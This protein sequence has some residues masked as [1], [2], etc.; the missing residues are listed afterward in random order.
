MEDMALNQSTV[1]R[2]DLLRQSFMPVMPAPEDHNFY[3]PPVK[4][5]KENAKKLVRQW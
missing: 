3:E 5:S 4:F 2:L 1:R